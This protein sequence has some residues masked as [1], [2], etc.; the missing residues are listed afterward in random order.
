[1]PSLCGGGDHLQPQGAVPHLAELQCQ[2]VVMVVMNG[3]MLLS[4]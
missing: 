2:T 4:L 1:M 3:W